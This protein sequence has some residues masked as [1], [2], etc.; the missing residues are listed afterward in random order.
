MHAVGVAVTAVEDRSAARA[1]GEHGADLDAD[2]ARGGT[3]GARVASPQPA[4][5]VGR[6]QPRPYRGV[7]PRVFAASASGRTARITSREA[8]A[9][10]TSSSKTIGPA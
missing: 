2:R 9:S 3:V 5:S 1:A 7:V 10:S 6:N 8:S 4:V